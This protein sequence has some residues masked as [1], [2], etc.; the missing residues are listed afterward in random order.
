MKIIYFLKNHIKI[1]AT[2]FFVLFVIAFFV[3]LF[4]VNRYYKE[5]NER[6]MF[7]LYF[8]RYFPDSLRSLK[9]FFEQFFY[10]GSMYP[11]P[12]LWLL[13][14]V[15]FPVFI[16]KS[17]KTRFIFFLTATLS[18]CYLVFFLFLTIHIFYL[19]E[20]YGV[21]ENALYNFQVYP[22]IGYYIYAL[23][24]LI[25]IFSWGIYFV[26]LLKM[27]TI[28]LKTKSQKIAELEERIKELEDSKKDE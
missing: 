26:V 11:L 8:Y 24:T 16:T 5:T 1:C 7:S 14:V 27:R 12:I 4:T 15:S 20:L 9:Y 25:V 18:V 21:G 28:T 22:S 3:P 2:I 13:F 17:K 19:R 23:L 10:G 6:V